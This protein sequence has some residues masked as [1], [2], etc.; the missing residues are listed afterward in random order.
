M[1]PAMPRSEPVLRRATPDDAEGAGSVHYASW[2]EAYTGLASPS[3]WERASQEHSVASWRRM[4]E[5]GL[6]ATV[7]EVDGAIVG[8][9]IAGDARRTGSHAPVRDRELNNLYVLEAHYGTG[10]G[11]ALLDAVLPPGTPAQLWVAEANPRACR[12]Y[13]RNGFARDGATDPG[14]A[15]GG[16]TVVRMVR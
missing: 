12:F 10:I 4:L 13:E 5:N 2:V 15:F 3:F 11:Q 16:I 1:L 6:D 8:L 14:A 7:A 9:A